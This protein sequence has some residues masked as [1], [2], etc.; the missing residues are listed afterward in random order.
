MPAAVWV[1]ITQAKSSRAIW[2]AEWMVKPAALTRRDDWLPSSTTLPFTSILTRS[3]AR[4]S[5]NMR[6]YWLIRKW[7]SGPGTRA[8]MWV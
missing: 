5:W 7:C 4:I 2:M 8:L 1:W 3:D 6:P